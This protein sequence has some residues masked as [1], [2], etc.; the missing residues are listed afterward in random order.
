[1]VFLVGAIQR[2][3]FYHYYRD[4]LSFHENSRSTLPVHIAALQGEASKWK[5]GR[6]VKRKRRESASAAIAG[7]ELAN[8]IVQPPPW[9]KPKKKP[10]AGAKKPHVANA[11]VEVPTCNV[12]GK[13]GHTGEQ[14]WSTKTCDI[15]GIKGHIAR[16]CPSKQRAQAV[17]NVSSNSKKVS[18]ESHFKKKNPKS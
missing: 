14:C 1:M 4:I 8:A 2:S 5:I 17:T 12:C 18:V 7:D 6:L 15:C 3:T 9:Q 10:G 13:V 16:V 11:L